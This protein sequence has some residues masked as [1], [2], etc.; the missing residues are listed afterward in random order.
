[1]EE[2]FRE[3][4]QN[5]LW[6]SSETKSGIGSEI[7]H[8]H[9]IRSQLARLFRDLNIKVLLDA[10]CG[11]FNWM[12]KLNL[13]GIHY[14]G[15]DILPE[16]IDKN[17]ARYA[18]DF[19][20]F[21]LLDITQNLLPDACLLLNRGCLV[22]FSYADIS[23]FLSI[24]HRSPVRYLVTTTFT[25]RTDNHDIVTGDWRPLNLDLAPFFFPKPLRVINEQFKAYEGHF[26]DKSLAVYRVAD[27]PPHLLL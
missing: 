23:R 20:E 15:C 7:A 11:D 18:K 6:E 4:Y 27:L 19:L 3:I 13:A 25:D 17:T 22:H 12:Q 26:P 1:M 8:T 24:L 5:N 16:I 9:E 21:S 2:T 14:K 10:H